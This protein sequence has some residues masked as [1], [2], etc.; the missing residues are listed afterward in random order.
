MTERNYEAELAGMQ[1]APTP[2]PLHERLLTE[3]VETEAIILELQSV[4]SR[5]VYRAPEPPSTS[6]MESMEDGRELSLYECLEREITAQSD[7]RDDLTEI[8]N[9]LRKAFL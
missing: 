4:V 8:I 2:A 1:N 7:I 3:R 6:A 9:R 5:L